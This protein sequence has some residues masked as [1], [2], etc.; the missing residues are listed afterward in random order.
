MK[1]FLALL[2]LVAAPTH[3]PA[4]AAESPNPVADKVVLGKLFDP[5]YPRLA[6]QARING[7]V[8]VTVAIRRD[9]SVESARLVNGHPML[10][11]AALDSARRSTFE[12]R[13]CTEAVTPYALKYKFQIVSR[14]Q[15][16]DC[17]SYND[18]QPE[19]GIDQGRNEVT[20]TGWPLWGLAVMLSVR[21]PA[22]PAP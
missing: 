1:L 17:D 7:D 3:V 21:H 14:G 22:L 6:L 10:A 16:K 9:G 2:V 20:V 11:E 19:P 18:P 13:G 5:I 15:A 8:D 4:Q 12:C